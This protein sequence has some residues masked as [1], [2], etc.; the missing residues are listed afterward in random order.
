MQDYIL[1][2]GIQEVVV[3][4]FCEIFI[5]IVNFNIKLDSANYYVIIYIKEAIICLIV[6]M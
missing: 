6:S 4:C 3:W 2:C 5:K 1:F